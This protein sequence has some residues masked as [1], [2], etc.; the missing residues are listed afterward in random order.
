MSGLFM[1][2]LIGGYVIPM[3]MAKMA[4]SQ[5]QAGPI[6]ELGDAAADLEQPQAQGIQLH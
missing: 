2:A 3:Q 5:P 4:G 6:A 1:E